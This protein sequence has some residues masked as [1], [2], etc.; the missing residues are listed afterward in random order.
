M[1][2]TASQTETMGMLRETIDAVGLGP[3]VVAAAVA[4]GIRADRFWILTHPGSE[5]L[6][7]IR[8]EDV[9][10]G[11]NPSPPFPDEAPGADDA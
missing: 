1:T 4:D 10:L 5:D 2:Q 9:K 3:E 8:A 6:P 7:G 11:R